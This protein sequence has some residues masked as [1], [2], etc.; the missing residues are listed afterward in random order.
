[1]NA[2]TFT[3]AQGDD[4]YG[5]TLHDNYVVRF[6]QSPDGNRVWGRAFLS[7][8]AARAN[9][10]SIAEKADEEGWE[11]VKRPFPRDLNGWA[12]DAIV[13]ICLTRGVVRPKARICRMLLGEV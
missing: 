2:L 10:L 13:D 9:Y 7:P 3:A 11:L 12:S 6:H 8:E 1:M 5:Y 4:L